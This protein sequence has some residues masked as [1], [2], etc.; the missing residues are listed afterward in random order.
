MTQ[1]TNKIT[2]TGKDFYCIAEVQAGKKYKVILT[3]DNR[4]LFRYAILDSE[5]A[6]RSFLTRGIDNMGGTF[7]HIVR[8]KTDGHLAIDS[9]KDELGYWTEATVVVT[10]EPND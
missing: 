7:T 2:N 6:T 5:H 1:F 4:I 8:P 10:E 3:I 9:F